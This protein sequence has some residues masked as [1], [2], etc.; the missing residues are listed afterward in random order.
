MASPTESASGVFYRNGLAVLRPGQ[1]LAELLAAPPSPAA[2]PADAPPA[3]ASP[4]DAPPPTSAPSTPDARR[5]ALP[6]WLVPDPRNGWW[7]APGFRLPELRRWAQEHGI[8]EVAP[9]PDALEAPLLD[10]RT[11][12]PYQ[13]EAVARWMAGGG[14]GSVVLPTGAG[15]TLVALMAIQRTGA[16]ACVVA[17]TRALLVQWF[18]QLADAFGGERVGAFYGDEKEVRPITVTTYHSAFRLLERE[19]ARFDLLVLDEV[20]HLAD[21]V[22]GEV[23][24]WHDALTVAPARHRLG[25]TATYPDGLDDAL[26]RLVGPVA[27]RRGIGEMTDRELADFV[28]ER[29]FIPLTPAE[30]Q[31]YRRSEEIYERY[32][33][34]QDYASRAPDAEGRWKLF[35]SDTRRSPKARRAFRAFRERERIVSL[36]EGKL[37]MTAR[38]L[39]LHPEE[40]A[41]LFCGS[42]ESAQAV[43]LRFAIPIIDA[44]TPASTRR[45]ILR[46]VGEGRIRAVVSVRV[47]DEGW[48]VPG[49]KLGI[50][51]GDST[52]GGRR[53]HVQRLGRLLRRQGDR[54]AALHELVAAGT[55]E[56]LASQKRRGGL[57]SV[58]EPQLGLGF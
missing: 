29:H 58:R 23:R 17:P 53:Q 47:L 21:A 13:E 37:E 43:S 55:Y 9:G 1:D 28:V 2:A 38:L 32:L 50:V 51:L 46:A 30:E 4:P 18:A 24:Q 49:A 57:K 42:K 31:R 8:G 44:D 27:Y 33:E 12:R 56:F 25:L 5:P 16:G 15:K 10:P 20:H 14:R 41:L 52:R 19:G 45:D 54:V 40:Q 35:M 39:R 36:S 22:G 34:E 11:P 3:A 6:D 48:D 26:L 7:I